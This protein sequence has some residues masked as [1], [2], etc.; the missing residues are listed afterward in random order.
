[1]ANSSASAPVDDRVFADTVRAA[2]RDANV[3]TLLM[4][5]VQL[6]GETQWLAPP[7]RSSKGRG[8][9]ENDTGGL[10]AEIQDEIRHAAAEAIIAWHRGEPVALPDPDEALLTH[11][12]SVAMG[13]EVPEE[14]GPMIA[15]DLRVIVGGQD[16]VQDMAAAPEG[17]SAVI[18]GAGISGLLAAHQLRHAS[19]SCTVLEGDER[20]GGTWWRNRYPGCGVDVPSHLYSY[21]TI[22]ADWPHYYADRDE[23]QAYLERVADEWRVRECI[24]FSTSVRRATWDSDDQK[25]VVEIEGP[26]GARSVLTAD[27]LISGV[28]AFGTPKLPNLPGVHD[29][30]GESCHTAQWPEDLDLAGQRVAVIGNGA[31]AMQVVPAIADT[32]ASLMVFQRSAHWVAPFEKFRQEIPEPVRFLLREVPLYRFWYRERLAWVLND[33]LYESLQKDPDWPYPERSIN[34]IN[35]GH[36]GF[37]TR[38]IEGELEGH[39]DLIEKVTPDYPPFG[40]RILLDNGWYRTLRRD[41]VELVTDPIERILPAGARLASGRDVE[42]DVLIFATGFDVVRFLASFEIIGRDGRT[43][44]EAWD[45]DD[46]QAYLGTVVPGFPNLFCLYGPN[47]QAGHGGSLIFYLECQMRYVLSL[48]D[49]MFRAGATVAEVRPEVHEKYNEDVSAAHE[50]MIW[51][52]PGMSTY[53][54]NSRGRVVVSNPWRVIDWWSMTRQA[55]PS[56]FRLDRSG[57]SRTE[58]SA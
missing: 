4:V 57:E 25:W 35:E 16:R 38:Y 52:H 48:L 7:Y 46:A 30:A 12:L 11:M 43:L 47:T 37:F 14:Y 42:F 23:L 55:D 27:I 3:P 39:P 50:R 17:F 6:T 54:R 51:T 58:L 34:A 15:D 8:L 49:Q 13:E 44:R 31:S 33:T 21:S 20:V 18:V 32:A 36:R 19:I 10:P 26:D 56:D 22:D 29:F 45:D 1:M 41:D 53:Y 5:L 28:G 40:K 2:V 9:S 24:R